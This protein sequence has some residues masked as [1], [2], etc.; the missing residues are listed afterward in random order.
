MGV[1]IGGILRQEVEI[2]LIRF[3]LESSSLARLS[4][5]S[6]ASLLRSSG[7]IG[8]SRVPSQKDSMSSSSAITWIGTPLVVIVSRDDY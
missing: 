6:M 2:C 3:G 8:G 5:V 7:G 4:P 1:S